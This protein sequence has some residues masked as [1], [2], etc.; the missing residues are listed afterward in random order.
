MNQDRF[1]SKNTPNQYNLKQLQT[2][3]E[4]EL[5]NPQLADHLYKSADGISR[6]MIAIF[7][8]GGTD[9]AKK[10][11][12]SDGNPL[13][14]PVEQARFTEAFEPH[15]HGMIGG[16]DPVIPSQVQTT[17]NTKKLQNNVLSGIQL[18]GPDEIYDRLIQTLNSIDTAV[19]KT[20]SD[21]GITRLEKDYDKMDDIHLIPEPLRNLSPNPAVRKVLNQIKLPLRF[22]IF[23]VF[24]FLDVSR[25]FSAVT[26]SDIQRKLLSILL[27]VLE[28]LRGDWKKAIMTFIGYYGTTP[29]LVGQYIKFYLFLFERLSPTL[30]D[31][32]TYG[33][34]D[35]SKS[36]IMGILLSIF[37]IAAPSI[38][39]IP[40]IDILDKIAL[41]KR[42]I[43][44]TLESVG[45]PPR[46][47][48]FSPSFDDL[49][50]LQSLIDDPVFICSC[51]YQTLVKEVDKAPIIH[52]VLE[53]LRIPVTEEMRKKYT[54]VDKE[55]CKPFLQTLVNDRQKG[56]STNQ[57]SIPISDTTSTSTSI[58]T[59][60]S[61]PS[62]ISSPLPSV[63]QPSLPSV[64]QPSLPSVIQPPLPS[65]IQPPLPSA[66]QPS[67]PSVIQ[68]PLPS[69]IKRGGRILHSRLRRKY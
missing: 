20:S 39:R 44:G 5:H 7:Q 43:D 27:S 60:N 56:L 49:T 8:T 63:I 54:C 35:V 69:V 68:P 15:L 38:I 21:Y 12:D 26:G 58:P 45:L 59:S 37:Q 33:A 67:L 57:V 61:T 32:I 16:E 36:F 3:V 55:P 19:Y 29:M 17:P 50:N 24:L 11:V 64:I 41:K 52:I 30:R 66:I 48:Y 6:V 14:T 18:K 46:E 42:E 62:S 28:L 1:G 65:A 31:R 51:E 9:W 53:L 25:L 2:S 13:L 23:S 4:K 22:I 10:I 34:Y 40:L 47:S